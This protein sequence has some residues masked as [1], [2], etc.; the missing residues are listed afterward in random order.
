MMGFSLLDL[1]S[2]VTKGVSG[3]I[4][5]SKNESRLGRENPCISCG[6]CIDACPFGLSPTRL[7]KLID[8]LDYNGAMD[9]GLMD[10]KECGCC[11]YVC[12]SAIPLVQG[13]KLGKLVSR[14]KKVS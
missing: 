1:D 8:H 2:P 13:L 5:L 11:S 12:P 3:I 14:K 7:Y 4:A 9:E 10:C 6:R